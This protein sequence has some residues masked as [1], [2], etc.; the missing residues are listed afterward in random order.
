LAD[1]VARESFLVADCQPNAAYL[2]HIRQSHSPDRADASQNVSDAFPADGAPLALHFVHVARRRIARRPF[3]GFSPRNHLEPPTELAPGEV[4]RVMPAWRA[5]MVID[6]YHYFLTT[7]GRR[8][9]NVL[10]KGRAGPSHCIARVNVETAKVEYLEVPV[11]VLRRAG[12]P[13]KPV[14]GVAVATSTVNSRSQD[15]GAEDRSRTGGW[16]IPA[17]WG[18]PIAVKDNIYFT[19]MPGITYVVNAKAKVLDE[20]ALVAIN[21]LGPSDETWTPNT[22]GFSD[23]RLY[24]R[25]LKEA[26][27]IGNKP[28]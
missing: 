3:S 2:A 4:I 14:Y 26:I 5:N 15:V 18:C 20:S 17:F 6:G 12:V 13:D 8:R 10:P 9:N 25:T 16:E 23:G 24:H 1:Y 11:T 7:V 28:L 19:T 27:C 22:P 21:D